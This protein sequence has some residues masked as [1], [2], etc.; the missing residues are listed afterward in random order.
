VSGDD[1]ELAQ[2][3]MKARRERGLSC[4]PRLMSVACRLYTVFMLE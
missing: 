4:W 1:E 2:R 3:R